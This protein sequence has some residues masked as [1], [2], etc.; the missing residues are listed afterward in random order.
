MG[1]NENASNNGLVVNGNDVTF[2]GLFVE[3]H[4]QYQTLWNGNRGRVY[5]YQCELPYD[6]PSQND[7]SHDGVNG[8]AGYK[9]AD[10]VKNHQAFGLGIYGVFT[11]T[12][13]KSFNAFET[14]P[15]AGVD[16]HHAVD[17]WITG[18]SGTEITHILNGTGK[19][20]NGSNRKTTIN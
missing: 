16:L 2:Y 20:V 12:P 6:A 3:H 7:W 18:Q 15:V 17:I 9:V 1:W 19:A 5:F 13:T 4:E 11:K 8:Y 10:S 14:P